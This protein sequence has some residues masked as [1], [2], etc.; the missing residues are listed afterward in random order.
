MQKIAEALATAQGDLPLVIR[1]ADRGHHNSYASFEAI[2]EKVRPIL[3]KHSLSLLQVGVE[4][5][6]QCYCKTILLHTS[7]ESVEGVWPVVAQDNKQLHPA[8]ALGGGWTYARR[9]SLA[10]ILGVGTGDQDLD[11]Q[12]PPQREQARQAQ[13]QQALPPA[14]QNGNDK[15]STTDIDPERELNGDQRTRFVK[16]VQDAYDDLG[17]VTVN[18]VLKKHGVT[19]ASQVVYTKKAAEIGNMLKALRAEMMAGG[20]PLN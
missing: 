19:A 14:P 10:S 3:N 4:I 9:Y 20:A 11:A 16:T 8:Q 12:E 15:A 17:D 2:L 1:K 7:G 13:Q 6:G 18:E 5:E